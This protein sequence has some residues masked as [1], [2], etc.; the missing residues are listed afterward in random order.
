MLNDISPNDLAPFLNEFKALN[1]K[2][3][4]AYDQAAQAGGFSCTGCSESC[5]Q[6]RF[7]HHTYLEYYLLREGLH[8]LPAPQ[9]A[10]I[11]DLAREVCRQADLADRAG[12]PYRFMCPV[13]SD[14]LCRLYTS[15]PIICRMHG[16]AH[17][18]RR[19]DGMRLT[20]TGCHLFEKGRSSQNTT[21]FE[22]T[23][24]YRQMAELEK[25]LR[26]TYGY[27]RRIKMTIA[28]MILA[29]A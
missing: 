8:T 23:P 7:Y 4:H 28:E 18:F 5:C 6:T 14:G 13:N 27:D 26:S 1:L 21:L 16:I 10:E 2:I 25:K 24:F 15:R 20:G 17:E 11:I 12:A 9:K 29:M 3:D 22:R 19:P